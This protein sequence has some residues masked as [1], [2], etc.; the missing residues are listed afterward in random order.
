M[1]IVIA[2]LDCI[3]SSSGY[4]SELSF[5]IQQEEQQYSTDD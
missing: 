1:K 5:Q 3:F 2:N 4:Y